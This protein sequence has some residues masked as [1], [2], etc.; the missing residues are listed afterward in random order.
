[1]VWF[2]SG[3]AILIAMML[4]SVFTLFRSTRDGV[5]SGRPIWPLAVAM[6]LICG[7]SLIVVK[8]LGIH[9]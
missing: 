1:M 8:V 5:S 9:S 2:V 3:G 6:I 4:L 7:S